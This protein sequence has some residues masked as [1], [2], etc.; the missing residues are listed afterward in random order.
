MKEKELKQSLPSGTKE[1]SS[2]TT[3][4]I[5]GCYNNCKYCYAKQIAIRF[6]RKTSET[7]V[8]E[9]VNHKALNKKFKKIEGRIMFPSSHDIT[10]TNVNYAIQHLHNILSAGN[11]VLIVTK[12]HLSVIE[13]L[14]EEFK[15]YKDKILFR[16]TIG[17]KNS[18]ILSFWEPNAPG[19]EERKQSVIHAFAKGYQTSLSG[20]PMLDDN[21]EGVV[22]DLQEYITETI[23]I[24]KMNLLKG[25]LAING[26]TDS[27]SL[28][29]SDELI[30]MQSDDRIIELY[31][32]LKDN[33][34]VRWKDSIKKVLIKNDI[35]Y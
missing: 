26:H 25:R 29:K 11:E 31:H 32:R 17:S 10:P 27:L 24:G 2:T 1:W 20:E 19:F 30:A 21:I 18:E 34:K 12:P 33:P 13:R 5:S 28:Q 3:N 9:E 7:W 6:K 23:W 14:C 35:A 22:N 15:N 4:Y 8:N 16:F